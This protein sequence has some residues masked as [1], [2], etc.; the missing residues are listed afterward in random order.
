MGKF[1]EPL[2]GFA[3]F[4]RSSSKGHTNIFVPNEG[5]ENA[6]NVVTIFSYSFPIFLLQHLCSC[7]CT[8]YEVNG[9]EI[10]DNSKC[11][12]KLILIEIFIDFD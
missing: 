9:S 12:N 7:L 1:P 8:F 3:D 5:T 2:T 11:R 6:Y 10:F 4:S